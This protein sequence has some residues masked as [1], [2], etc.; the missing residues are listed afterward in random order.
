MWE[1]WDVLLW[2]KDAWPHDEV[3]HQ[4]GGTLNVAHCR[5]YIQRLTLTFT[6]AV[7]LTDSNCA[8][9]ANL[10]REVIQDDGKQ[11]CPRCRTGRSAAHHQ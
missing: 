7:E 11:D 1:H 8:C 9:E 3:G 5:M 2:R 4:Q 10:G 6:G